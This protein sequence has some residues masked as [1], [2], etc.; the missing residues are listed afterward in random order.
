MSSSSGPD[1]VTTTLLLIG[2]VVLLV[3]G[4]AGLVIVPEHKPH[5]YTINHS[6]GF[7][8]CVLG[9]GCVLVHAGFT[10]TVYNV[11]S[12]VWLSTARSRRAA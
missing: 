9:D 5:S 7:V 10:Q 6:S 3:A 8:N 2:G 12:G 11:A 4:V 1:D